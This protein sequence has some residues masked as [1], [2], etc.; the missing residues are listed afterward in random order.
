MLVGA[1]KLVEQGGL[2]AVLVARQCKGEGRAVRQRILP[3][4]GVVAAALA[5]AGV[6]Y[7]FLF[8]AGS[9]HHPDGFCRGNVDPGRVIQPEGQGVA[10]D[11]QLHRVTHG[12]KLDK[13]DLF[14]RDQAHIQ[15]MLAEGP[16]SANRLNDSAFADVQFFQCHGCPPFFGHLLVCINNGT[17]G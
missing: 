5:Q 8:R 10:V 9:G 13:G 11:L 7:H 15:K 17:I 2:S 3:L 12:C 1:G 4:F 14:P 6:L 16:L